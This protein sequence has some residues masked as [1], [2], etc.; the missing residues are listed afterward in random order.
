MRQFTHLVDGV[1]NIDMTWDRWYKNVSHSR[2]TDA[3]EC[4]ALSLH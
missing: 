1:D 2:D 4:T 3:R